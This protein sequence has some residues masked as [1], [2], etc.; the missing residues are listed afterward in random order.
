MTEKGK[1]SLHW[2]D[3]IADIVKKRA[4]VD[5]ILKKVVREK[6]YIVYDEKTPSGKIHIGAGRG[7]MIHDSIAKAM[8]DK[9]M[10]AKF[11]LSSDDIDPFDKF[12]KDL[13]PKYKK[14]LGIPFRN[15]PSP[16]KGYDS[17]ADYYFLE[18]IQ[19]FE[20]YGIEAEIQSTGK[21]Y[22]KGWLNRT[23]KTALDNAGK[24]QEIYTRFSRKG[25]IAT[26]RL[27]INPICEKCGKIG[28]T[29]AYKW[30][31]DTET[32]KYRCEPN[33]VDWAKGCGYEGETSPYN[34][35]AKFPWKVEWAAK[36]P[37]IGVAVEIAGKDH[38]T[39]GGSRSVAIAISDEIFNYPPPYPSTRKETGKAYEFF[40]IG[41]RKMSTSKGM[42]VS[43]TD[44]TSYAPANLL[45]YLLVKTR[46]H[47][48]IDFDPVG[49]NKIILLYESYDRTERIYYGKEH[50]QNKKEEEHE[51]RVYELSHVS[52]IT[53]TMPPQIPFTYASALMQ[54]TKDTNMAIDA[55]IGTGHI[56]KS[57]SQED[58]NHVITRLNY[59]KKWAHEFAPPEYKFIINKTIP[60]TTSDKLQDAEISALKKFQKKISSKEE[61]T[62][63]E[64]QQIIKEIID[65]QAIAPKS[66]YRAAY[67]AILNKEHG[68][69][70]TSL[71]KML[72]QKETA[73][74]LSTLK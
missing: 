30:D 19:K 56:K 71:I 11:I 41:G 28:T 17:F 22:E 38:F 44:M 12:N 6:G 23:I 1:N 36:W 18:C 32:I 49:T 7:W 26:K 51:K 70:L 3:R 61:Y 57:I 59:A 33:M 29:Y 39:H 64:Y 46:P 15:M 8:R 34:G 27:P 74:V 53:K 58:R 48:T 50:I 73:R 72:G 68:P 20:E 62:E 14:Y 2:A 63:D 66:F 67:L 13:D 69:K 37:T 47:A 24:I 65:E 16:V 31:P 43:F 5:P 4:Q 40:T 10:K 35:S 45:R 52:R 60:K 9:G 55:L 54:V 42:G 21:A 25:S